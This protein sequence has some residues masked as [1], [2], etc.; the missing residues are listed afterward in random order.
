MAQLRERKKL[1]NASCQNL[2]STK[3]RKCMCINAYSYLNVDLEF[4]LCSLYLLSDRQFA[5]LWRSLMGPISTHRPV[6]GRARMD[7]PC[8]VKPELGC[9]MTPGSCFDGR[10]RRN[11]R[12]WAFNPLDATV[13]CNHTI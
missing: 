12:S 13:N 2:P 8:Q 6:Y 5:F 11:L 9:L 10:D 1:W 4:T 3:G 7:V